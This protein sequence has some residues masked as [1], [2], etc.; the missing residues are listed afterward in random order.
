MRTNDRQEAAV[1]FTKKLPGNGL[2]PDESGA[3]VI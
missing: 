3:C 1:R 2:C